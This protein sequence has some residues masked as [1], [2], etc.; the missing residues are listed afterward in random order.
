MTVIVVSDVHLGYEK[1]KQDEFIHFLEYNLEDYLGEI[2][3]L[4]LLG[5]I[6]DFWRRNN[7][8]LLF[9]NLSI[10]NRFVQ[11]T[12]SLTVHY[13]VGNHD[14]TL[15]RMVGAE[16]LPF[17]FKDELQMTI[18]GNKFR[19]VHG[20]QFETKS[21]IASSVYKGLSRLLCLSGD[22][23]GERTSQWW[24]MI[25]TNLKEEISNIDWSELTPEEEIA[26]AD[27]K[28]VEDLSQNEIKTLVD[29][30]L[31]D[32]TQ[33]S[34]PSP[35]M[36]EDWSDFREFATE[37]QLHYK[38]HWSRAISERKMA[39]ASVEEQSIRETAK[40]TIGLEEDEFLVFGH[41][42]RPF[43]GVSVANSGCWIEEDSLNS[44]VLIRNDGTVS[45]NPWPPPV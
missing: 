39:E 5:D 18:G 7:E 32:V 35:I 36:S 14:F 30:M 27:L 17:E 31:K 8:R 24:D 3:H 26:V 2:E 28:R 45:V 44:Y 33:R 34:G 37:E 10:L 25:E 23:V 4:V 40:K 16:N 29:F 12:E 6:L 9:E 38:A 13:V 19:F 15:Q 21:R 41:T 42:H 43:R 11:Y 22:S 1:S 20:H